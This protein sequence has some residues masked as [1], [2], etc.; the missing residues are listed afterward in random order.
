MSISDLQ[1]AFSGAT[2]TIYRM[3]DNSGTY[4]VFKELVMRGSEINSSAKKF[5]SAKEL[6]DA[7]GSDNGGIG[8]VSYTYL[9]GANIKALPVAI[10]SGSSGIIPNALTIQSEKYP[11]CRRLYMYRQKGGNPIGQD[12][13]KWIESPAGQNIVEYNGFI[14]LSIN[15]NNNDDNP[16]AM[17][18]DPSAYTSL[19][20]DCKKV[21]SELR[22]EFGKQELDSRAVADVNR[23]I[24]FLGQSEN[25]KKKLI[26]VGFTDN[27]GDANKNIAL[28]L[29]RA[30]YVKQILE[31][32]GA[33]VGRVLGFGSARPVR[34][35]DN[36]EDRSNNRRVEIWLS[37]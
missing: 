33:L 19:I 15:V 12:L 27:I 32:N 30:N 6:A 10:S 26:L 3:D 36:E 4:K 28:S 13:L 1:K 11:L 18:G 5:S 8:F 21:S 22:F 2:N 29:Q 31:A 14:N 35:N 16:I 23:I 24:N 34:S 17:P 37:N 7:V 9:N 25:R 20:K